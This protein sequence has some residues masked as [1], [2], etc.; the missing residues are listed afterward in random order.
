LHIHRQTLGYR[1]RNL[2]QITGR[3]VTRTGHLARWWRALRAR[4]LLAGR[5]VD[6][7]PLSRVGYSAGHE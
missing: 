2:E 4:D 3:G 1:I 5:A 6:A 7:P